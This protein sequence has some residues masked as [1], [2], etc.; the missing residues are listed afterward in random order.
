MDFE[1]SSIL[2]YYILVVRLNA[3]TLLPFVRRKQQRNIT[4]AGVIGNNIIQS[5]MMIV[6]MITKFWSNQGKLFIF[7]INTYLLGR[8]PF[9]RKI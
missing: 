7:D 5:I 6:A 1:I 8:F 3:L 4:D 9:I 2:S